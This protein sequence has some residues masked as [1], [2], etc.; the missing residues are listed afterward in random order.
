MVRPVFYHDNT[1]GH[2]DACSSM[3]DPIVLFGVYNIPHQHHGLVGVETET[4]GKR[5]LDRVNTRF[6]IFAR[7]P[8]QTAQL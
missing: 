8:K 2:T 3:D 1:D 5:R 4:Q 7:L 6:S